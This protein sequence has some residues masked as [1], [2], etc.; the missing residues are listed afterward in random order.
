MIE[1]GANVLVVVFCALPLA[2]AACGTGQRAA[3]RTWKTVKG[4]I[5]R[6]LAGTYDHFYPLTS[7]QT[8]SGTKATEH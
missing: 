2:A 6:V 1:T 4:V 7:G 5:D 3:G 8:P